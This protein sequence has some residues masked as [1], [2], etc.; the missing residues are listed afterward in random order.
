[1]AQDAVIVR[2]PGDPEVLAP[3][4][5]EGLRRFAA[6]HP[7]VRP[8]TTF[9]GTSSES[10]DALVVVMLWPIGVSHG[11]LARYMLLH[12]PELKL[13]RPIVDH[14]LVRASTFDT[15]MEMTASAEE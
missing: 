15:A 12:L 8:L 4:Y 11:L 14:V 10:P 7:E 6:E 1:M 5:A 9:V 3:R 2:F 13:P